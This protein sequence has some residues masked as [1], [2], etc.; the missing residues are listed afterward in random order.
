MSQTLVHH[1]R[2]FDA[3]LD[4]TMFDAPLITIQSGKTLHVLPI[5]QK[6]CRFYQTH[7]DIGVRVQGYDFRAKAGRSGEGRELRRYPLARLV[8]IGSRQ[9]A[10]P[11]F[12][13]TGQFSV[14]RKMPVEGAAERQCWD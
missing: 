5:Y 11:V 1:R 6:V 12:R 8:S 13:P 14:L 10:A 9:R 2:V 3:D 7:G 4:F